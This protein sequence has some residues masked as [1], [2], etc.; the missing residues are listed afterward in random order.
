MENDFFKDFGQKWKVRNGTVVFQKFFVN[1]GLTTAVFR[2]RGTM[3][4]MLSSAL[5]NDT[6]QR[7]EKIRER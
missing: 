7:V 2:S 3:V 4:E 5:S 1:R 6:R